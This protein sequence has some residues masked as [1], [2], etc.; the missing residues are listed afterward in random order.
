MR[1]MLAGGGRARLSHPLPFT[2]PP[3]LLLTRLATPFLWTPG[4]AA[5]SSSRERSG[6]VFVLYSHTTTTNTG[7]Y[8][9]D[10]HTSPVLAGG[11]GAIV[12]E[13]AGGGREEEIG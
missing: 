8:W 6:K 2:L 1:V 3:S 5:I 12:E 9:G 4:Y 11:S 13:G 10:G 7:Q